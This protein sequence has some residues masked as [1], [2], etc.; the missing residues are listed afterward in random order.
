[1]EIKIVVNLLCL[2]EIKRNS[3]GLTSYG[4]KSKTNKGSLKKIPLNYSSINKPW[5]NNTT[6]VQTIQPWF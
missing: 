1:M 4:Q 3:K 6:M 5:F 2:P